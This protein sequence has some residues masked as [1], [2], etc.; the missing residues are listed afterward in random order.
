MWLNA[1]FARSA[2]IVSGAPSTGLHRRSYRWSRRN[3]P[4]R[5]SP[6]RAAPVLYGASQLPAGGSRIVTAATKVLG[7]DPGICRTETAIMTSNAPWHTRPD[8][9]WE[10]L[11]RHRA[12]KY[13]YRLHRTR[14]RK[15]PD[16]AGEYTL[17]DTATSIVMLGAG[18][19]ATPPMILDFLEQPENQHGPKPGMRTFAPMPVGEAVAPTRALKRLQKRN[20]RIEVSPGLPKLGIYRFP[21]PCA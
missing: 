8:L 5:R 16:N 10:R 18:F 19:T 2:L 4:K 15:A 12:A 14:R 7:I 11:A 20:W 1:S 21:C 6:P 3:N 17:I 13:G 9:S